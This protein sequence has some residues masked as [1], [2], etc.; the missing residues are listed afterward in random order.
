MPD[1]LLVQPPVHD[2]YLTAKRTIPYG[3]A[4]IAAVLRKHQ[5][6]VAILDG[7]STAK[8]RVLPWPQEL[9]HLQPFYGRADISPFAL[10]HQFR[11]FG[12]SFEHIA[13]QSRDSDAYLVGIS[14]PFTA[15]SDTALQTAAAVRKALPQAVI[16]LGGHHPTALPEKVMEHPAVDYVLRGDGEIGLPLLA[17]AIRAGVTPDDI[18]G[19][20]RRLHDGRLLIPPPASCPDLETLPPPALD[21]IDR[22]HY[23]RAGRH[24]LTLCATRGCPLH[25]TYCAVNSAGGQDLRRRSVSAVMEEIEA[26]FNDREIGFI[27]FED[28]H[29]GADREWFK[30]LLKRLHQRFG[31][32]MPE[33]R[34][35]NGLFAP[36]LD[37]ETIR[38]MQRAGFKTLNLALVTTCA[39]QLRRF[40]RPDARVDFDRVLNSAE[41]HGLTAVAY[42]IVAGPEQK[43]A[44]GVDDLLF[45][46]A[47]RVLA[48]VSVFYPAPGSSD[49]AWCRQLN[50][51][52]ENFGAMRATALP[53]SHCTDRTQT[54]TLLRLGRMLNFMKALIDRGEPLPMPDTA[55]QCI[56]A[57]MDRYRIGKLLV[58]AFLKDGAIR[59]VDQTGEIYP[60]AVDANLTR[61][62]MDGFSRIKLRGIKMQS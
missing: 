4:L 24:C 1:I 60:H 6:S 19:L 14:S 15:Y 62:F 46:A 55:P 32:Q 38:L 57:G 9:N 37:E 61:Q 3:L 35:M 51:L 22:R 34:A 31:R 10:F 12:Y 23:R 54:V 26:A 8:S 45:L 25:C 48:G 30:I 29:L 18:P 2:F 11:R 41:R 42:V 40:R 17:R 49:Y 58:A 39:T 52:P 47:R 44:D 36:S 59:G 13:R 27:D 53:L 7:L 50:L 33:L 28:E 5:F 43:P 16:V 20:V 56:P 21:L